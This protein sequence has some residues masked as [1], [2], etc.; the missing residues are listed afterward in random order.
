VGSGF[1]GLTMLADLN[2]DLIKIDRDLVQGAPKS[3]MHRIIVRGLVQ[4][5]RDSGCLILAKGVET[6]SELELMKSFGVEL[7]QGFLLGRPAPPF[8]VSAVSAESG[9][10]KKSQELKNEERNVRQAKL[11]KFFRITTT[12]NE[13]YCQTT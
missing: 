1:A 5:A 13:L 2:P 9:F 10:S 8:P 12:L 6:E 4:V 3:E 7:F 11:S